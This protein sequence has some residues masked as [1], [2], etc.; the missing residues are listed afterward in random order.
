MITIVFFLY[1]L[2]LMTLVFFFTRDFYREKI[3]AYFDVKIIHLLSFPLL[4]STF[5]CVEQQFLLLLETQDFI[6]GKDKTGPIR[7]R[8]A[9]YCRKSYPNYK[10]YHLGYEL[11]K[12]NEREYKLIVMMN[13]FYDGME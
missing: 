11:A 13:E 10:P 7:D 5:E 1:I 2:S 12:S 8:W 3:K 6:L 4:H 9:K